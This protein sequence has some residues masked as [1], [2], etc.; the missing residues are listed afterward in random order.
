MEEKLIRINKFLADQGILSRRKADELIKNGK[1]FI[2][3]RQ[4]VVGDKV[5]EGD[6]VTVDP[7]AR[8]R[9]ESGYLYYAY[10][11]PQGVITVGAEDDREEI[12]DLVDLPKDVVP[13]GRLDAD[14]RGLLI[15][16]N[17]GRITK[18]LLDPSFAHE[19]EYVVRVDKPLKDRAIRDLTR[20]IRLEDGITTRPAKVH[21]ISDTLFSIII[22][23]GKKHQIRRMCAALGLVVTDLLRTRVG[24]IR[25][26]DLRPGDYREIQ[27]K[28]LK[29]FLES[30][31]L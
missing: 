18:R 3:G 15:L 7:K 10:H 30:I 4:A 31:G 25:L 22:T 13:Q 29:A 5:K 16:S 8:K 23:E 2:N 28:E 6:E 14:S 21:Q 20:G 12:K 17:D 24:V 9:T 11:K 19:K 26:S 1:V 27:G